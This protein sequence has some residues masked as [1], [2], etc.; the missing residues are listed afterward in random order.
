VNNEIM[1]KKNRNEFIRDNKSFIYKIT[2]RICKKSLSWENDDELSIALI[3]F[4]KACDTYNDQ[5]GEFFSYA[6]LIIRNFLIDF[7]RKSSNT[8]YLIFDEDNEN[9]D[10]IDNKLSLEEYSVSV[11]NEARLEEIKQLSA[12]L[13]TYKLD[14]DT[15]ANSS[16]SH[17]DTRS[18]LLNIA[19]K[20]TRNENILNHV[21]N[22]KLLPVK[23]ICLLTG[24]NKKMI[25]KW[26]RYILS[27]IIILSNPDYLYIRSYL[28]IK[29]GDNN[30]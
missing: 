23:E 11:E 30:D 26:R 20:C 22:K 19:F 15:L 17:S 1:Q 18:T 2:Q 7:F 21:K 8:P 27:L 24:A 9:S 5:K 16:P 13:K 3:A 10:Y 25:E 6:K 28:N 14:F 29:V 4:N 12:E